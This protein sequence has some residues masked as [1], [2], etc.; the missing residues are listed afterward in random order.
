MRDSGLLVLLNIVYL[1]LRI[2]VTR[3]KN[4]TNG[5]YKCFKPGCTEPYKGKGNL[6]RHMKN[7]VTDWQCNICFKRCQSYANLIKHK[8][9]HTGKKPFCCSICNRTFTIKS[10]LKK[11]EHIHSKEKFICP[12]CY[13]FFNS[14]ARL[15]YH[16]TRHGN[17]PHECTHCD[18]KFYTKGDLKV[19][20][21]SHT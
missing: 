21:R 20:I 10:A 11:H 2:D 5:P 15:R 17:K 9:S 6:L 16:M 19:H 4:E 7:T 13:R 8:R 12:T 3:N 18:K 14:P 1:F